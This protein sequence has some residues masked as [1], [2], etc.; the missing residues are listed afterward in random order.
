[1]TSRALSAADVGRELGRSADWIHS[2]WQ[3]LVAEKK[4]PPP[5]I[6]TGGLTWSAAQ[7][8]A[9]L[10]RHLPPAQRA[11]AAAYRAALAA[12]LQAPGDLSELDDIEQS[13]LRLQQ[14]RASRG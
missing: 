14:R 11:G 12:A 10:D 1:M 13:R 8:Y 5:I 6:E 7:V 9:V 4:L 2:N 3:K